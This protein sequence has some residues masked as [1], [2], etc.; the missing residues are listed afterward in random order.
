VKPVPLLDLKPQCATIR[1]EIDRTIARVVDAQSFI[2]GSEVADFEREI[3]A[4]VGA[5]HAIGC[6]SGTDALVLSLHALGVRGG[7]E[8]V[9]T[10][11]SFFASASCAALLGATP[12][13]ADIDAGTFNIDPERIEDALTSKTKAIVPVHLFGQCADMDAILEIGARRGIPVIEDA[14]QAIGA[15]Y[16]GARTGANRRAGSMGATGAFSFFPSKNLGAFGDGGL[17]TTGDDDLAANLRMLRVHG[18]R[19]RYKHQAIGWNSRLDALQAAVL[20]VKL[21]HLDAWSAG[22]VANAARYDRLFADAGLVA[23]EHVVLPARASWGGHIFNQYTIRVKQRDALG[24]H[25]KARGIGYG[26][27]YPIPLHLQECFEHLG[28]EPDDMPETERASREVLSL[29][30]FPEL[31]PAQIEQVVSEIAAFFK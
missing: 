28:Y 23:K 7:D 16:S 19:E 12:V 26:I 9:T 18:E 15:G 31:A 10:P 8:I 21:P 2:L 4:Y 13:F 14:C 22:R 25:L 17:V 11:F 24:E 29:P 6:A 30:I 20:R 27:Y 1:E 5:K 3:A